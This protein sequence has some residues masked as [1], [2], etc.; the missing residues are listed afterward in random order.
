MKKWHSTYKLRYI[1]NNN[2][3]I[4]IYNV[5]NVCQLAES[6]GRSPQSIVR[7]C[8]QSVFMKLFKTNNINIV[9]HCQLEFNFIIQS[10][11]LAIPNVVNDLKFDV[12]CATTLFCKHL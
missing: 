2:N 6:E 5:H 11:I 4:E 10:D 7:F 8:G 3:N 12:G 9:K 1:S